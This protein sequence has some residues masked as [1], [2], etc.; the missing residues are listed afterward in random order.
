[1]RRARALT[2]PAFEPVTL[3]EAKQ[4]LRV[5]HT[6][7]DTTI[8]HLIRAAREEI[9][10]STQHGAGRRDWIVTGRSF[11][12]LSLLTDERTIILLPAPVI[13]IS[14]IKYRTGG[15][16][17]VLPSTEYRLDTSTQPAAL[18]PAYGKEWPASD[19]DED[20]VAIKFSVGYATIDEIPPAYKQAVLMLVEQSY[21]ERGGV[22][23]GP[24]Y[25][26]QR[27]IQGLA[28]SVFA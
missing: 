6:H 16:S 17:V 23:A 9:E 10:R 15:V 12:D 1:M 13:A 28:W 19:D 4:Y 27:A 25:A 7:D 26:L 18:M 2:Q 5:T 14:E 20:S 22:W 8:L 21:I 24:P 11:Q 3:Q